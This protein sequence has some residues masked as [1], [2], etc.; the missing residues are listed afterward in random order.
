MRPGLGQKKEKNASLFSWCIVSGFVYFA[1]ASGYAGSPSI[2]RGML[3]AP[4]SRL[5]KVIARAPQ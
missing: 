2:D 1:S 4:G 3:S 5:L